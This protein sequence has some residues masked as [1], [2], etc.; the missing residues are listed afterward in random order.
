MKIRNLTKSYQINSAE[1]VHALKGVSFDLPERG[2]V[3]LLGKSGS[4]K[5]TLLNILGGLD[6]ATSGE[7]IFKDKNINGFSNGQ[8]NAYRNCVCGFIFQEYNVIPEL[9][10]GEN[11]ALAIELQGEKNAQERVKEV[12]KKVDLEGFENRKISQLS[13]GQKQRVA[14]ARAL[15]KNSE[16]IFADEPTGA[17]DSQTGESIFGLLKEI[18]KEKLVVAVSHDEDFARRFADRII[19]LADGEIISDSASVTVTESGAVS[20]TKARLPAKAVF[21][22]GTADFRRSPLKLF[23]TALICVL[24]FTV[25]ITSL[26]LRGSDGVA[27]LSDTIKSGAVNEVKYTGRNGRFEYAPLTDA[28][29][30]YLEEYF[31]APTVRLS[32]A[33]ITVEETDDAESE[34]LYYAVGVHSFAAIDESV[35]NSFGFTL[36]GSLPKNENEI[37]LSLYAA[38]VICS[39]AGFDGLLGRSLTLNGAVY[40]VSGLVD[41][42]FD[43]ERFSSLKTFPVEESSLLKSEFLNYLDYSVHTAVYTF[44]PLSDGGEGYVCALLPQD[45]VKPFNT[46]SI[47]Q[48]A[49]GGG[50]LVLSCD[51]SWQITEV[52]NLTGS[53]KDV[54]T[55]LAVILGVLAVGLFI[56]YIVQGVA[57]KTKTIGILK[58]LG[59]S[60]GEVIKIFLIEGLLF[61]IC[62]FA[63][64]L[65]LGLAAC[66]IINCVFA[67]NFGLSVKAVSFGFLNVIILFCATVPLSVLCGALAIGRIQKI[68]PVECISSV[69]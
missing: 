69:N 55:V 37:A 48:L 54:L 45:A 29:C 25:F 47:W 16:I 56:Y 19:R 57:D 4:G 15:I 7:I 67:V 53:L 60:G 3:F 33:D 21:K 41:T 10:V 9:T 20:E 35:L 61:G 63:L 6:R 13:G 36:S 8:L 59:C 52:T 14:I 23:F 22:I 5:T 27:I 34:F 50:T 49:V 62:V 24:A 66:G 68:N 40:T 38:E 12:L 46:R 17:L 42:K 1:K 18:S 64:S 31:G 51:L 11:I 28:D 32:E 44:A 26:A 65:A 58:A 30:D 43:G 39:L 2:M